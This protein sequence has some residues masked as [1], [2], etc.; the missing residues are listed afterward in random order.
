MQ[1]PAGGQTG[2]DDTD[3]HSGDAVPAPDKAAPTRS[4]ELAL[5][6][7]GALPCVRCTYNLRGLSVSGVCPECGTAIRA[8]ILARVDPL[9]KELQPLYT[10]KLTAGCLIL[11]T[12]GALLAAIASWVPRAIEA[13]ERVG[14]SVHTP[15][16]I[17]T[18]V[19]GG[20]GVSAL[21]AFALIRPHGRIPPRQSW[22]AAGACALYFPLLLAIRH[23]HTAI[24][25]R[26]PSPYLDVGGI[27]PARATWR[28]L[29]E[30]L[31]VLILLLLRPNARVLAARSMVMRTGQVDRQ[32][33][34]AM[35]AAIGVGA[36]GDVLAILAFPA[37]G[38]L[39]D[40]LRIGATL[41]IGVGSLLVTLGL[42]SMVLDTI[43]LA[44]VVASPPLALSDVAAP[45]TRNNLA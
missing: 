33:M 2:A 17:A 1:Q 22:A 28:L 34:L 36:V 30:G 15:D 29:A 7:T 31:L 24:D 26:D 40:V 25:A 9:A 41:F 16:W 14:P 27:D 35:A 6:L 10:P 13:L 18:A 8:T 20:I 38:V 42:G 44:P 23:I 12:I 19:L 4:P 39:A 21:A 45:T 43:R 3:G 37:D 11:W 5:E 32:T